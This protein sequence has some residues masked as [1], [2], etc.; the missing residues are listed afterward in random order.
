M[1][2]S[3]E[4][5]NQ[6]NME[7]HQ[8]EETQKNAAEALAA[9]QGENGEN[10][11]GLDT[12]SNQIITF[13]DI[14]ARS[15]NADLAQ[16]INNLQDLGISLERIKGLVSLEDSFN[17]GNSEDILLESIEKVFARLV[18]TISDMPNGIVLNSDGTIDP[19]RSEEQRL[20]QEKLYDR[21]YEPL[22]TLPSEQ[23]AEAFT[24]VSSQITEERGDRELDEFFRGL[25]FGNYSDW[26]KNI[27]KNTEDY[28]LD[29]D[30]LTDQQKKEIDDS[31]GIDR[32]AIEDANNDSFLRTH[33]EI[34]FMDSIYDLEEAVASGDESEIEGKFNYVKT[35]LEAVKDIRPD[36]YR[37]F[38]NLDKDQFIKTSITFKNT[39]E[40]RKNEANLNND[41]DK[42]R[43]RCYNQALNAER[44]QKTDNS[45]KQEVYLILLRVLEFQD[46]NDPNIINTL[47]GLGR[48]LG[49]VI[50]KSNLISLL[51][52]AGLDLSEPEAYA[53]A[54]G[55]DNISSK[56]RREKFKKYHEEVND[57]K[58]N[59]TESQPASVRLS[60]K[61]QHERNMSVAK[62]DVRDLLTLIME[63]R[64]D[65]NDPELEILA[66]LQRYRDS[67]DKYEKEIATAIREFI[68]ENRDK[69]KNRFAKDGI[70]L[71]D[72]NLHDGNAIYKESVD[73]ILK[74]NVLKEESRIRI[75]KSEQIIEDAF[76]RRINAQNNEKN[77]ERIDRINSTLKELETAD[78][79]AVYQ[80]VSRIR[81]EIYGIDRDALDETLIA[82]IKDFAAR[83]DIDGKHRRELLSSL[84]TK[85][86]FT[87]VTKEDIIRQKIA[88]EN[89]LILEAKVLLTKGDDINYSRNK[90]NRDQ[91]YGGS[92]DIEKA[93]FE[94]AKSL[95]KKVDIFGIEKNPEREGDLTPE[96][97]KKVEDYIYNLTSQ[98]IVN[99]I[100]KVDFNALNPKEQNSFKTLLIAALVDKDVK[101]N[102]KAINKLKEIYP[103]LEKFEGDVLRLELFKKA[104]G[105]S[106]TLADFEKDAIK[107]RNRFERFIL[108]SKQ[109]KAFKKRSLTDEEFDKYFEEQAAELDTFEIDF[110]NYDVGFEFSSQNVS[111][112][113]EDKRIYP[114]L[115]RKMMLGSW[116]NDRN[117]LIKQVILNLEDQKARHEERDISKI[118][119]EQ[120]IARI[121]EDN[122][123]FDRSQIYDEDGNVLESAKEDG[124]KFREQHKFVE[125]FPIIERMMSNPTNFSLLSRDGKLEM[126]KQ[127]VFIY[128]MSE[129]N[130]NNKFG[131]TLRR[132]SDMLFDKI[133]EDKDSIV[134]NPETKE[135]DKEAIAKLY[136]KE[137]GN[138]E[139]ENLTFE[140]LQKKSRVHGLSV[141]KL[142]DYLYLEDNEFIDMRAF[143]YKEQQ[144]LIVEATE[145]F[146]D[147]RAVA[148]GRRNQKS[149]Y[150]RLQKKASFLSREEVE[151]ID[152]DFVTLGYVKAM[153]FLGKIKP[154]DAEN[155]FR[156]ISTNK[157]TS[158]EQTELLALDKL[159]Y[160][161]VNSIL[162][163]I[164]LISFDGLARDHKYVGLY[165]HGNK[166]GE[167][168][169]P[170]SNGI[171]GDIISFDKSFI[172]EI[173][174]INISAIWYHNAIQDAT[175][176]GQKDVVGK[177]KK[178]FSERFKGSNPSAK[179][180]Q[181]RIDLA[182][183]SRNATWNSEQ[184][185]EEIK[186]IVLGNDAY[187]I[188]NENKFIQ[189]KMTRDV[190]NAAF[191]KLDKYFEKNSK[192]NKQDAISALYNRYYKAELEGD[193]LYS[194]TNIIEEYI[195][196][197]KEDFKEFIEDNKINFDKLS[198]FS[199]DEEKG[200]DLYRIVNPAV[201][202]KRLELSDLKRKFEEIKDHI[203]EKRG[204]YAEQKYYATLKEI[205]SINSKEQILSD[206]TLGELQEHETQS[207]M[208]AELKNMQKENDSWSDIFK[209]GL[210]VSIKA[211]KLLPK[212]ITGKASKREFVRKVFDHTR[213]GLERV[214]GKIET[215]IKGDGRKEINSQE[216]E[217]LPP[218]VNEHEQN[219]TATNS[220]DELENTG[221]A[222]YSSQT[223]ESEL[224]GPKQ[225]SGIADLVVDNANGDVERKARE[226]MGKHANPQQ[227]ENER[228]ASDQVIE[229]GP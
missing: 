189:K 184:N 154:E 86:G 92:D 128:S 77:K 150:L 51:K 156:N 222:E 169:D 31:F 71:F 79:S 228:S 59:G 162:D 214:G 66:L 188:I 218:A 40:T 158:L 69:F 39:W 207:Y 113:D 147:I 177:L 90:S 34:D 215:T 103:E 24:V 223:N 15:E 61:R 49:I 8:T 205:M 87:E 186:R 58:E 42:L 96:G 37:L 89:A 203:G 5:I 165:E 139:N 133:S 148:I 50:E 176:R 210:S 229:E 116:I 206:K 195:Y 23:I 217:A 84:D 131:A 190:N 170:E 119:L 93:T 163:N 187:K 209:G 168:V 17:N 136:A 172:D 63:N 182:T 144:T 202:D 80:L 44:F 70:V 27:E 22:K 145:E 175:R 171:F 62:K 52:E 111:F 221:K 143:S 212:L 109:T 155:E 201:N 82:K 140:Q 159:K 91:Y 126:I 10:P 122:P 183:R 30:D 68:Y 29:Y 180:D 3:E 191:D 141:A 64:S 36:F 7:E 199:K 157:E 208:W 43:T 53:T 117:D 200:N 108:D 213:S 118:N 173:G 224:R 73:R 149:E 161:T 94:A 18:R 97:L 219:T 137:S 129:E 115:V 127:A 178:E 9:E 47:T 14:L 160:G 38:S 196:R 110:R 167:R 227:N 192:I 95:R 81:N 19:E 179:A 20:E 25:G 105:K 35:K 164:S 106:A 26:L 166:I 72:E 225:S 12:Q 67:N 83:E 211:I 45:Y 107:V 197:N 28:L 198:N 134:Y 60:Q 99:S 174:D 124:Y 123:E 21:S 153:V 1:A 152:N 56:T 100:D 194:G 193:I 114:E 98:T 204:M 216:R 2:K 185:R 130:I 85:L 75:P 142:K 121:L 4:V 48:R 78:K 146:K 65:K 13:E 138:S 55:K 41:L 88:M 101:I 74:V 112:T 76:Q 125:S 181:I 11:I 220:I 102:A 132:L 32:K 46:K 16:R 135:I 33:E 151:K 54:I 6:L 57:A 104:Y 226:S 120:Q